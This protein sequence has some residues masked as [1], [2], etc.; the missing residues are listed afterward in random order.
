MQSHH[1]QAAIDGTRNDGRDHYSPSTYTRE[2][3]TL[4]PHDPVQLIRPANPAG[5]YRIVTAGHGYLAVPTAHP[6]NREARA[7][8]AFGY[9]GQYATYLEEDSEA[10]AFIARVA[11]REAEHHE[12]AHRVP[13]TA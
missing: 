3:Q 5:C 1:T 11:A 8:C 7:L 12:H 10:P 9:Q 4:R 2:L 6:W 13:V